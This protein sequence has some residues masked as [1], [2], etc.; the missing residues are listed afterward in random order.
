MDIDIV[1]LHDA[2]GSQQPYIQAARDKVM[3]TAQ[4]IQRAVKSARFRVVAFRDH[5]E[6]G[7]AWMVH[8]SNP[9]TS[10]PTTL[11]Q[12]LK[13]LVAS[14]GGDGPE[15]QI[16]ALDAV[17]RS[18]WRRGAKRVV[19]L[20]T[21]SPPHGIGE[22]GDRVP[23]S[24]P[25]ALTAQGIMNSYKMQD[26][27]LTVL[28]CV[29]EINRYKTAAKWYKDFA[30]DTGGKYLELQDPSRDSGPV[31]RAVVGSVLYSVDSLRLTDKWGDWIMDESHRGHDELV[32]DLHG[33]L[34]AEG[35]ECHDVY[36]SGHDVKYERGAVSRATVD[37]IVGKTLRLKEL[38]ESDDL[39]SAILG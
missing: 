33:K 35:E 22:P 27:Q 30:R 14:G 23:A 20:I 38:D 17:L 26:I 1:F 9:F 32:D 36:C 2:T 29:P 5:R 6:Q 8:D 21:D 16:D 7:D 3:N 18:S 37:A 12:Q 15:A 34:S 39:A 4:A 13:D 31:H 25:D 10:D 28:A 24:H 19:T 11:Q